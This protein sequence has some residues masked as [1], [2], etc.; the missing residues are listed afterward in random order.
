[1]ACGTPV[2]AGG[3]KFTYEAAVETYGKILEKHLRM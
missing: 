1:M 2:L 3:G